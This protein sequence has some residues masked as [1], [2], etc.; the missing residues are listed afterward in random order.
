MIEKSTECLLSVKQISL[1]NLDYINIIND[2]LLG[3]LL[4]HPSVMHVKFSW[5][6]YRQTKVNVFESVTWKKNK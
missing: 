4:S 1:S 6:K 2:L 5:K 3:K